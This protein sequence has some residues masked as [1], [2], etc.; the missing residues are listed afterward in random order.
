MDG[1]VEHSGGKKG[2]YIGLTEEGLGLSDYLGPQL[3]SEEVRKRM[4]EWERDNGQ[5]N[6]FL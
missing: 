6:S 2:G 3:I 5:E 1:G 4:L